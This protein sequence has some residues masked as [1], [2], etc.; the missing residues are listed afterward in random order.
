MFGIVMPVMLIDG[1]GEPI[2]L[3]GS[4][5]NNWDGWTPDTALIQIVADNASFNPKDGTYSLWDPDP[6]DM[7]VTRTVTLGRYTKLKV[8]FWYMRI[9]GGT[10]SPG[11]RSVLRLN[12]PPSTDQGSPSYTLA[13]A[14]G[15]WYLHEHTYTGLTPGI[16][17]HL[18]L[19]NS[20]TDPEKFMDLWYVQEIA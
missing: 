7:K 4:W 15:V 6:G 8:G 10:I 13:A 18:T 17:Y 14:S 19:E 1:G 16:E 12:A 11:A 2:N 9:G 3:S 5:E 20:A